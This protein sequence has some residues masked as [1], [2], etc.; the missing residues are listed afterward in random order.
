MGDKDPTIKPITSG[1]II[2]LVL[3][4]KKHLAVISALTILLSVIFSSPYFITPLYKS[5][6]IEGVVK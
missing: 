1:V 2:Q 4:Y 3:K 6:N 5:T